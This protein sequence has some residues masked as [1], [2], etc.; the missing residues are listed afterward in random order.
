MQLARVAAATSSKPD[1]HVRGVGSPEWGTR[2][3]LRRT[4]EDR[5]GLRERVVGGVVAKNQIVRREVDMHRQPRD[6]RGDRADLDRAFVEL[7]ARLGAV[8]SGNCF[9][10]SQR[11]PAD[12]CAQVDGGR[13]SRKI[14]ST[15]TRAGRSGEKPAVW[16]VGEATVPGA[17]A[18]AQAKRASGSK[19]RGTEKAQRSCF[20]AG[21]RIDTGVRSARVRTFPAQPQTRQ[22]VTL[23]LKSSLVGIENHAAGIDF[24]EIGGGPRRPRPSPA[25]QLTPR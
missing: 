15:T 24:R 22:V 16:S 25:R 18:G 21:V 14:L 7:A 13:G 20:P 4:V 1:Q 11:D 9:G 23:E 3:D 10:M 2:D 17:R 12:A 5:D 6:R 8:D 19:V